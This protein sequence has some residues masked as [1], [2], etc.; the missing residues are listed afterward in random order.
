MHIFETQD[1]S[2]IQ[3][4]AGA[5]YMEAYREIHTE[6]QNRFSF[7]EMYSTESLAHQLS[8]QHSHF[9][10]LSDH[11]TPQAYMA[12]CPLGEGRWLLDKLY[13]VPQKKGCGY[14]RTLVEH[15]LEWLRE[16]GEAPCRLSLKVNRRNAAVTFYQHLG[17]RVT[18]Q[19][20]IV[21]A[22]G[23]WTMDG[24]DMEREV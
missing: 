22:D 10:V 5:C 20:D 7:Y 23:R 15:A 1:I 12:L 24:Y 14:G 17:F 21:I 2:L 18:G 6:E 8:E 4:L 19:W 11:D 3:Q 9:F 13:V 16:A